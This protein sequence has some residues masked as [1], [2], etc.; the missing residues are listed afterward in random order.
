MDLE[1]VPLSCVRLLYGNEQAFAIRPLGQ[2]YYGA[3]IY[4]TSEKPSLVIALPDKYAIV[5]VQ[6]FI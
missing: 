1:A 4:Q 5:L 2:G 3:V 6:K